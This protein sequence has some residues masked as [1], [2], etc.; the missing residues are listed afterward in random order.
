[1]TFGGVSRLIYIAVRLVKTLA[2]Y[3]QIKAYRAGYTN[4]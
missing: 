2:T 4:K 3:K 1:M